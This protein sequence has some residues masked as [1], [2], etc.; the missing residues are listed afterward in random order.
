MRSD[1]AAPEDERTLAQSVTGG[2]IRM[3]PDLPALASIGFTTRI[4]FFILCLGVPGMN[5]RQGDL[6]SGGEELLQSAL[7]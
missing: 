5:H 2:I 6:V 4:V 1:T 7:S 3:R